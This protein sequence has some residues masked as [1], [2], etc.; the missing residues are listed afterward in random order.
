[1]KQRIRAKRLL[2]VVLCGM[3]A[4]TLGL[5]G[6]YLKNLE[7]TRDQIYYRERERRYCARCGFQE[8]TI[9]SATFGFKSIKHSPV[10][11]QKK[12]FA[13]VEQSSCQHFF[14]DIGM[15]HVGFAIPDFRIQRLARGT[16]TNDLFWEQ[17]MLVT[18]FRKL[19]K[20]ISWQDAAHVFDQFVHNL[21][22]RPK[23]STNFVEALKGTNSQLIV[24]AMYQ[25]YADSGQKLQS[26]ERK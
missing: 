5:I 12:D 13:G 19:E 25:S 4:A 20:E 15:Q 14:F 6:F 1:M 21:K 17:P 16:L 23:E 26:P 7:G 2:V 11:G 3:V 22:S 9:A 10:E 18:S 8:W 24:D